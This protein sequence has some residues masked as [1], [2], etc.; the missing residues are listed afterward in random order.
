MINIVA[1]ARLDALAEK[2]D[3]LDGFFKVIMRL[4]DKDKY[5]IFFID[6]YENGEVSFE[7][8]ELLLNEILDI[9]NRLRSIKVNKQIFQ[10][11]PDFLKVNNYKD[12]LNDSATNMSECFLN[13]NKENMF[14]VF[15]F[16]IDYAIKKNAPV[17]IKY[18]AM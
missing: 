14:E 6:F 1:W 17:L 18:F 11:E 10:N 12:F 8:L 13:P 7:K 3:F 4:V 9:E 5:P 15:R 2:A 16:N